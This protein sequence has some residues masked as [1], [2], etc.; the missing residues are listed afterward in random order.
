MRAMEVAGELLMRAM[1]EE[2]E[3]LTKVMV[4]VEGRSTLVKVVEAAEGWQQLEEEVQ[5]VNSKVAEAEE[6]HCWPVSW[7][8]MAEEQG[9]PCENRLLEEEAEAAPVHGWGLEEGY[10]GSRMP[11]GQR[12]CGPVSRAQGVSWPVEEA[13]EGQVLTP[14][15]VMREVFV[16]VAQHAQ[17]YQRLAVVEAH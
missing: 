17:I 5:V 13:G 9:E 12:T 6:H 1:E 2:E 10:A 4:E 7:G 8:A 16:L 15:L 3:R 11:G 14:R